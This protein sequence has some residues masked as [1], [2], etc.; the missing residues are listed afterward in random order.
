MI[1]GWLHE[2]KPL[3]PKNSKRSGDINKNNQFFP[4][5]RNTLAKQIC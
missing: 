2:R 5:K 1:S 4:V 3:N